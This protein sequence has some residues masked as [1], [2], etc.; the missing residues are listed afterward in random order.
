VLARH[1]VAPGRGGILA[2]GMAR[3]KPAASGALPALCR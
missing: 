2:V 3:G 1:A